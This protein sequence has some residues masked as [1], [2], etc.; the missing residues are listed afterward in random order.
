MLRGLRA[1]AKFKFRNAGAKEHRPG[2][3]KDATDTSMRKPNKENRIAKQMLLVSTIFVVCNAVKLLTYLFTNLVSDFENAALNLSTYLS[4]LMLQVA[5]D[6]LN[7]SFNIF[8]Y[9][10]YNSKFRRT[11]LGLKE[12]KET[13]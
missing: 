6:T 13:R 9:Y 4:S 2:H 7:S 5:F 12:S 10:S 1:A 11:F 3:G 8:V